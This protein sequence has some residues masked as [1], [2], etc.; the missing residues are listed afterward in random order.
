ML[1][2]TII[3]VKASN[4]VLVPVTTDF[5]QPVRFLSHYSYLHLRDNI[6]IAQPRI[7]NGIIT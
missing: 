1:R 7:A 3:I 6:I 4:Q 2:N 5:A